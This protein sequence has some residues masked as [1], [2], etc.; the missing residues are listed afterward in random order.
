MKYIFIEENGTSYET[1]VFQHD[2]DNSI[3][4]VHP[5]LGEIIYNVTYKGAMYFN[6]SHEKV[7]TDFYYSPGQDEFGFITTL[8]KALE[9]G[10]DFLKEGDGIS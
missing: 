2:E 6:L 8:H 1:H 5:N 4:I 10:L 9:L 7:L 3:T